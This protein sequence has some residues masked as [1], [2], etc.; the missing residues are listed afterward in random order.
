MPSKAVILGAVRELRFEVWD[1]RGDVLVGTGIRLLS[2]AIHVGREVSAKGSTC[3]IRR[4][5]RDDQSGFDVV[6]VC[7]G[8]EFHRTRRGQ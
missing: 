6:G 3:E 8:G 5:L 2:R 7:E 1:T 4:Y